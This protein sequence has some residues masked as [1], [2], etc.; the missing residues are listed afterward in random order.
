VH[1][2]IR[3][4]TG[5][6]ADRVWNILPL[7]RMSRSRQRVCLQSGL[8]PDLNRLR[9]WGLVRQGTGGPNLIRWSCTYTG[10][11]IARGLITTHMEVGFEA[12]F[13][14]KLGELNQWIALVPRARH[15]GGHQW[16]F[17]C[18]TTSR[19][20]SVPR[21]TLDYGLCELAAKFLWFEIKW[22]VQVSQEISIR[23]YV[24]LLADF[25]HETALG[26]SPLPGADI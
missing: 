6:S 21:R 23:C 15:F 17:V 12:W 8:K 2:G 7:F 16:Y 20:A 14:I 24:R 19:N 13:R 5:S 9:R 26:L 4:F 1:R 25:R 11:E 22:L 10:E 3:T 18:P